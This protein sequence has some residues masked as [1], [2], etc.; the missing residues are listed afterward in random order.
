MTE[1]E[2]ARQAMFDHITTMWGFY[3]LAGDPDHI[4]SQS[5]RRDY[6]RYMLIANGQ[7]RIAAQRYLELISEAEG[8]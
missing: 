8:D 1:Q 6:A 7:F 2:Q 3:E 4:C 5:K